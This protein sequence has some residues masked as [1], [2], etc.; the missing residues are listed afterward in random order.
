MKIE[1]INDEIWPEDHENTKYVPIERYSPIT[2]QY[3]DDLCETYFGKELNNHKITFLFEEIQVKHFGY[4][5]YDPTDY[6]NFLIIERK[7]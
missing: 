7:S 4:D 2:K 6:R 3:L 1:I 5:L